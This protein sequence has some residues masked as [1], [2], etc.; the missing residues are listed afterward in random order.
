MRNAMILMLALGLCA[1]AGDVEAASLAKGSSVVWLGLNGNV[2]QLV[3]PATPHAVVT[4]SPEFGVHVAYNHFLS[5]AWTLALSGGYDIGRRRFKYSDSY[6]IPSLAGTEEKFTSES[7]NVRVGG[8][9]YAFINDNVA[10]YAGPGLQFWKGHG[11]YEGFGLGVDG[12]WADVT[13]IGFNGRIGMY[14][15]FGGHSGLFGH[16]GQVIARNSDDDTPGK[17]TW[18]SNHHEG[19]VGLAF[20]F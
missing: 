5:D 4:E 12:T 19:S 17:N 13:Q 11:K 6:A 10:L 1:M 15:R 14:A 9:R 7:F 16:I 2:A 20:D 3:G 18:W 8:D